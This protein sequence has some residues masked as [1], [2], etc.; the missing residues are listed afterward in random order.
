[1]RSEPPSRQRSVE[2]YLRLVTTVLQD[3]D[4]SAVLRVA[5]RLQRVRDRRGTVYLAGNGGS[6]ATASHFANDLSKA[7]RL[8]DAP[9]MRVVSL[10]D[11]L[12]WLTAL[13]NDEGFHRI[14]SGQ[15]ENLAAPGDL[16]IV[17]SASGNS[18]N[19]V[20]AVR[21]AHAHGAETIGFLGFDGGVLK[22]MVDDCIWLPTPRG[23]YGPVEDVHL[24][25]CHLL[26][27]YLGVPADA[28]EPAVLAAL[29]H[30]VV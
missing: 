18:P 6:A 19:L 24:V 12:S 23:A 30:D 22:T 9:P 26:T 3:T 2:S 7:T 27:T 4:L 8:P 21:T 11:H 17:I 16:L 10:S 28:R 29:R 15:L 5:D 14:F 20:E 13:G 1:M 25:L